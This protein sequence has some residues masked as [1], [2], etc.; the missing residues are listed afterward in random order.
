MPTVDRRRFLIGSAGVAAL[1]ALAACG[2]N[3]GSTDDASGAGGTPRRGGTLRVGVLGKPDATQQDPHQNLSNDS[4][5]L[6]MSLVYDALTVPTK[7]ENVAPRLAKSWEQSQ[8]GRTWTFTIADGATFH[9]GS[10][11]TA[12]DVVWSLQRIATDKKIAF[13]VPVPADQVKVVDAHRFSLTSP[14]PNSQI[15][16]LVRLVTFVMKKDSAPS[17]WQGSGPFKMDTY[18]AGRARLVRNEA[19]HGGAPYVDAIEV[20]P[21]T[22]AEAMSNA[23]QGGSIDLASAVGAVAGRA[24]EANGK[25]AVIRRANDSVMPII[26]RTASGPFA[27]PKVREAMRLIADRPQMVQSVL[28]GYGTVGNDVLGTGDQFLDT[29]LPQRTRNLDRAKQLLAD[30]KFDTGRTYDF[31]TIDE[32]TG[33]VDSAKLFAKQAAEAGVKLEVKVQDS[34]AFYD[35]TWCK[36]D[37]YNM[38]WGTNDSVVFF[39]DKVLK[40][41]AK[42]NETGWDEPAFEQAYTDLLAAQDDAAQRAASTKMQRAE[43]DNSGYLVWGVTDGVDVA[44][45]TVHGLPTAPGFGRMQLEKVWLAS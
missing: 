45:K 7:D 27:D 21:F 13:K 11:V 17:A 3:S 42:N 14:Q 35:T 43:Y 26:M 32:A 34:T 2:R 40:K 29:S 9:D 5:F 18:T 22:S 8:D 36:A 25:L 41:D 6:I 15:P 44:A 20:V 4:D 38:T 16:L 31:F 12:D 10:P 39:A 28:S 33:Q 19:W 23:V 1:A 30:A 37:L 24:A